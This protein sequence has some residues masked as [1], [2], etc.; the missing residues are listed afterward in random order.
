MG[1]FK[2]ICLI[3]ILSTAICCAQENN[4]S[5]G[6]LSSVEAILENAHSCVKFEDDKKIYLQEEKIFP[7][8]QGVLVL[9]NANGEYVQIPILRSDGLG[10]FVEKV[11]QSPDEFDRR[12]THPCPVCG[13]R[14]LSGGFKCR[15]ADCP[16]NKPKPKK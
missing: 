1:M 10:C 2:S 13:T 12:V 11:S 15:N 3:G 7:T 16:S 5:E 4:D 9:L 14:I 6:A 8:S